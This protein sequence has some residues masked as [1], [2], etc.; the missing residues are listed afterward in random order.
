MSSSVDEQENAGMSRPGPV[1]DRSAITF[2]D[3]LARGR[4]GSGSS[5]VLIATR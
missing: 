4:R 5:V 3:E 1:L 2:E